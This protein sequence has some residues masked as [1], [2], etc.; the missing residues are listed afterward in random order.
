MANAAVG[1][2]GLL[3]PGP[4]CEL[5]LSIHKCSVVSLAAVLSAVTL[6]T[7]LRDNSKNDSCKED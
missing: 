6:S 5:W 7:P 3:K 4:Y 2:L 1:I